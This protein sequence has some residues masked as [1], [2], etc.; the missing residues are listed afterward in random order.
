MKKK[1][2]QQFLNFKTKLS[3]RVCIKKLNI[4][5][6]NFGQYFG[7]EK[8]YERQSELKALLEDYEASGSLRNDGTAVT[9]ENW[10]G[11]FEWDS[12]VD[13]VRFNVFGI[14][15][16]RAN[17]REISELLGSFGDNEL[18][19]ECH[20]GAQRFLK[21]DGISIPSSYVSFS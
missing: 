19:P 4:L 6:T 5:V 18:S 12:Q 7:Q 21:P 16:Y 3:Y 11:P 1:K 10:L 2:T 13:D 17:Q 8:L 9:M 20:D 14:S 15:S